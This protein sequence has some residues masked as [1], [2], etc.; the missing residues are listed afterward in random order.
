MGKMVCRLH[1]GSMKVFGDKVDVILL[2]NSLSLAT[3]E[4]M[5]FWQLLAAELQGHS[6]D[7]ELFFSEPQVLDI[8]KTK[9]KSSYHFLLYITHYS[10]VKNEIVS[11]LFSILTSTKPTKDLIYS[12]IRII[13]ENYKVTEPQ[14]QFALASFQYWSTNMTKVFLTAVSQ[15]TNHLIKQ[16]ETVKDNETVSAVTLVSVLITWW[17]QKLTSGKLKK[18]NNWGISLF[19]VLFI[20]SFKKDRTLLAALSKLGDMVGQSCPKEWQGKL[21][22]KILHC[23]I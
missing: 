4:T 5:C 15:L 12:I 2:N 14:V 6:N 21:R 18:N 16:I 3:Y 22:E 10:I 23:D 19:I 13:P 17:N 1:Y 7:I 8:L 11:S 9:C 20:D